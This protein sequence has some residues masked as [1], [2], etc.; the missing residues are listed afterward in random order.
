MPMCLL[1][2]GITKATHKQA[3]LLIGRKSIKY[4]WLECPHEG[5][6]KPAN[7]RINTMTAQKCADMSVRNSKIDVLNLRSMLQAYSSWQV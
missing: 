6:T 4:L 5:L 2:V 3:V 1:C 7:H